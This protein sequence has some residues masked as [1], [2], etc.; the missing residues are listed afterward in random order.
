[1]RVEISEVQELL[2][3]RGDGGDAS[4]DLAGDERLPPARTLVI[5]ENAVGGKYSV[6]LPV[7]PCHPITVNFGD[8]VRTAWLEWRVLILQQEKPDD[9]VIG[10]GETH[11]VRE[12]VEEAFSYAGLDWRVHVKV[13]ER[14]LRPLEV[15]RLLANTSKA[16]KEL[17]WQ[18]RIHFADLV[19][20]MVD[21]D[22]EALGLQ[23]PGKGK[24]VLREKL[25]H[26]HQWDN[27]VSKVVRATAGRAAE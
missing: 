22:M 1:M 23:S 13:A 25:G 14:Y 8:R 18:P 12:F 24:I 7:G 11:S 27:S 16:Q 15:Q 20:I 17:Q 19:V 6:A 3:A 2:P 4:G 26:W 21:A 10:I 5:E 9:F